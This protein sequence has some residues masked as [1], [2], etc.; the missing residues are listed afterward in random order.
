[1]AKRTDADPVEIIH[2]ILRVRDEIQRRLREYPGIRLTIQQARLLWLIGE[3][4][5]PSRM[6]ELATRLAANNR[7]LTPMVDALE[8]EGLV[9]RHTDPSDRRA[10]RVHMTAEGSSRRDAI[11]LA[12]QHLGEQLTTGLSGRE[13][14]ELHRLLLHI[15]DQAAPPHS[16]SRL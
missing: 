16:G 8:R 12:E 5:E 10:V 14:A 13:R 11:C 4:D 9:S 1:V 15:A 7:T 6:S 2:A 3:T